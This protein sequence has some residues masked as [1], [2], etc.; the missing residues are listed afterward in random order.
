[1]LAAGHRQKLLFFV[2]HQPE[3]GVT[4]AHSAGLRQGTPPVRERRPGQAQAAPDTHAQKESSGGELPAR[5]VD[6]V[7]QGTPAGRP[8]PGGPGQPDT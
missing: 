5:T 2:I 8:A 6:P 1:M 7:A 4:V 3:G